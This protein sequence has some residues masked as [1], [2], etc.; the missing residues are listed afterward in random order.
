MLVSVEVCNLN[1]NKIWH[2]ISFRHHQT[3]VIGHG[4]VEIGQSS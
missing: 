4:Q 1:K 2:L 3:V